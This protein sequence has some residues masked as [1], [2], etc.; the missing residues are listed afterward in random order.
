M[1]STSSYPALSS[2]LDLRGEHFK[3]NRD[4]WAPVLEK[5]ET[6]L[7][8]AAAEGN[9][10]ST[11]RHQSRGQLLA[12]DRISLLL[13]QDSPFLELCAFAGF[14]NNDST[15][16]ANLIAGI[17]SI[18]GR[19]TMV[20]SHIPTQSGGAWNEMTVLKVNRI[21]EVAFENN[22]PLI[23]LVQS[24]GVFLP[25]Q[26]R[27]FH[28][29]GQLFHDLAI[30]TQCGK[31]SCAIVFGSSTA[32]GAYHPALSDYTIF[33]ENQ[34]QAFLGGPPLVKM[35]TG[36]DIGAEELGG[37][38]VHATTTGLAD[39]IAIDEF[40][41]IQKA[42]EWMAS[43]G[44]SQLRVLGL[45]EPM[46]PRYPIDDLLAL[47]NPEIRKP[48][49]MREVLLRIIDDSRLSLFKPKYGINM[50][51]GWAHIFGFPVGI[52]ANQI[53]VINPHE[54]AKTAQFIR[55]CNQQN[56]PII[57]LHNVTG[58]MVGAK[59]EH[60][61]IIKIGAQLVSAVSCSTVPHI[62]VILGASYGAG[63]YAMCGR[64]YRPRFLFAWPTGRCSVMGPDQLSGVMER[65]QIAS[66]KS[67]GQALSSGKLR[68]QVEAFREAAQADAECYAT[69]SMLIDDGIIDPR[70]TRDI[71]G[72]CLEVV[73]METVKGTMT[74]NLDVCLFALP[75][76]RRT[77]TSPGRS[78]FVAQSP[79]TSSGRPAIQKLLIANRG[80]IVCRIAQTCRKLNITSVAIYVHED[81]A[82]YHIQSCDEA[83]CLGSMEHSDTNPFLDIELLVR[84]ALSA[85]AQAIHPGYGYLSEN[86]VFV[87]RV[88]EAGLIFIG[89]SS[90]AMSTL[91]DKRSSKD[92]LRQHAP[93][94]PLVP[95]FFGSSQSADA[96]LAVAVD[97]GFPVMLKASAGGGGKGMRIVRQAAQ[98]KEEL[99]RAQ[100]EARRSFGSSDLI[101]E[102]YLENSKH[103][104]VQIVGD[105]HGEVLS[106]G[107]RDCSVQR[108]HQKVIEET[109]CTFLPE[110]T[111]VQ[112]AETAVR[113]AK[114]IGYE[115]A[116]TVE[117]IVDVQTGMFYFLEV[118]ARLQVEHPITE[119]VMGVDLVSLQLFV[120]SGGRLFD[121]PVAKSLVSNGHAIECRL[122]AEDPQRNFLPEHGKVHL[123]L[124]SPT[125]IGDRSTRFE[126]AVRTG[127][128]ISIY[129]D[130]MIAKVV[131]WAP[132]RAA[133]IEKMAKILS[134]TACAGV[135][136]NQ[137]FLQ[138]CLAHPRFS[139]PGY[140]TSF[141]TS[142][143]QS[144]LSYALYIIPALILRR[145]AEYG[146]Q[147]VVRKPFQNVR[148]QFR[149]QRFD[150][151]NIHCDIITLE[152]RQD[153]R[154][155]VWDAATGSSQKTTKA[156]V[157][158][159]P[160]ASQPLNHEESSSSSRKVTAR[161][162]AISQA[163]RRGDILSAPSYQV[164]IRSWRSTGD[165]SSG[166]GSFTFILDVIINGLKII[167]NV[168]LPSTA[169]ST[170]H[171]LPNQMQQVLCHFPHLGTWVEFQRHSLLSFMESIR[172]VEEDNDG[173]QNI[174]TAPMPCRILTIAKRNGEEVKYGESLMVVESMK[175]EMS[176]TANASGQFKTEWKENDAIEEGKVLCT[177]K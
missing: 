31:P 157:M 143:L 152:G 155:C 106:F 149:N 102:K 116:G 160:D 138:R 130:S 37:A 161:Y 53:S 81:D 16:C 125:A 52:V 163:L 128:R 61:G 13:D 77:Q 175:M 78:L 38:K 7:R 105:T 177:V 135:K 112:M 63:N 124:P 162:N 156:Y 121:L 59:A 142:H 158:L 119:E 176:I 171:H 17:G 54:A 29:G 55:L 70:D 117:F 18:S 173:E 43:L 87:D 92:Y 132:T 168:A 25:Q 82:S 51:T 129:F 80:E 47:V 83:I 165:A 75:M 95:G 150:P 9:K 41:A 108:R 27:V 85:G 34:A 115:N 148:K 5:F 14:G 76:R 109:P 98:L 60:N 22:L 154:L 69:S 91:G 137:L 15:P 44:T 114:L 84:T 164:A 166:D 48:F 118:N 159:L 131:V 6:N 10:V 79:V 136:T 86:A 20:M 19:P 167:T 140:T 67:K 96:L 1:T 89:P 94:V 65:V 30:R 153:A 74:H 24:A 111:R 56:T 58:F 169:P 145:M 99:E 113:I 12:R 107:D 170:L 33:V 40:D 147:A 172:S 103:V 110:E 123:W 45:I 126:T 100:S 71:L 72:M 62:S 50:I 23:S 104:E 3:K 57:F 139:D 127:S 73:S 68:K 49:D 4:S 134:T 2:H 26:F 42:R 90:R 93:D 46:T 122:C 8:Q 146:G 32:G 133:A 28:K 151:V 35:A 21:M 11:D 101:L 97:I 174:V 64:A 88:R 66:A 39:Q 120:S 144:L 36:E 141:I